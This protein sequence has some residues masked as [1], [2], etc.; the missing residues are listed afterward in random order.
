[1]WCGW[2][3]GLGLDIGS[4][5]DPGLIHDNYCKDYRSRQYCGCLYEDYM[6][7]I[8]GNLIV[9]AENSILESDRSASGVG[10]IPLCNDQHHE[11]TNSDACITCIAHTE[12]DLQLVQHTSLGQS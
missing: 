3:P 4:N 8:V 9:C 12:Y 11:Q 6:I 2:P 1:M 5:L 10:S 7:S